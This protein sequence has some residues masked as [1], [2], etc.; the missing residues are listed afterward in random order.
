METKPNK[1]PVQYE[2]SQDDHTRALYD[3]REKAK[4]DE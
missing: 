2:L 3:S 4:W 1:Q